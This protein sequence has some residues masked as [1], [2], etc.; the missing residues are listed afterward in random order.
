MKKQIFIFVLLLFNFSSK[1]QEEP[2]LISTVTE[3]PGLVDF[4]YIDHGLPKMLIT[5]PTT[6]DLYNLDQTLFIS[7]DIPDNSIPS[8]TTSIRYVTRSLFDCDT[9]NIEFLYYVSSIDTNIAKIIREDGEEYFDFGNV[10]LWTS[11]AA[12]NTLKLPIISDESGSYIRFGSSAGT[13]VYKLSGQVPMALPRECDGSLITG[14]MEQNN[15]SGFGVYPN[16]AQ[17]FIRFEYDLEGKNR[18][19]LF[20]FDTSGRLVR[21]LQLGPAFDHIRLNISNLDKGTYIARIVTEDGFELS[22]K[23]VKID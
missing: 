22:E 6:I 18:A 16:P 14:I 8:S 21:E 12:E 9:T 2:V 20:L 23:F 11:L 17:D 10:Y 1:G 19:K 5:N 3:P 13:V 15:H 4:I 7:I